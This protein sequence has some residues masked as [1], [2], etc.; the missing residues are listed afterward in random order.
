MTR[1]SP[2]TILGGGPAGLAVAY[3][4]RKR[5]V[6]FV[7]WEADARV[8]GNCVTF[9]HGEFLY[10]SGAHRFH[11]VHPEV[12]REVQ[13]LMGRELSAV[14]AP[15]Q[16]YL[17]GRMI[18]FPLAPSNLIRKLGW[19]TL[20]RAA[21]DFFQAR[22]QPPQDDESFEAVICSRYGRTI[23]GLF[24]L[25]Y[26]EK[27][28]GLPGHALSASVSGRRLQGLDLTTFL[29]EMLRGAK[30][31]TRHLDGSFFY[32]SQGYGRIA[33]KLA[34]AAGL[35]NVRT[36][37]RVTRIRHAQGRLLEIEAGPSTRFDV[38]EVVST[39]PINRFLE[40]LDPAPPAAVLEQARRLKFRN[41]ILVVL[42]LDQPSVTRNA[43][44]YFPGPDIP[45]TRVSEPRNRSPHLAPA[46]RTSLVVELC[47]NPEDEW[48]RCPDG[49]LCARVLSILQPLGWIKP[50]ALLGTEVRRIGFAYPLLE[51]GHEKIMRNLGDYL[52]GFANLKLTGRNSLFA[53]THLHDQMKA[54]QELIEQHVHES[55]TPAQA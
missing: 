33:E 55:P 46:G 39:L 48:W 43:S 30:S 16:I 25:G 41:L 36:G 35:E 26:S 1:H 9:R 53:Y 23:A 8:G 42:F 19:A 32:P 50:G 52:A 6:P 2:I 28:W 31:R 27:L 15:S 44:I 7:L 49:E 18:D 20:A 47:C 51:L 13:A 38:E 5:G 45:F 3:Y 29:V 22:I 24:V 54:G 14:S 17:A 21:W 34:A 12:T 37:A 11:D 10:D 4:A 40:L